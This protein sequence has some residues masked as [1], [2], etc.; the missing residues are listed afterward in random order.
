MPP[1]QV[2]GMNWLSQPA[3]VFP[4]DLESWNAKRIAAAE[5]GEPAPT[6]STSNLNSDLDVILDPHF[7]E[8]LDVDFKGLRT[9]QD[10]SV[11]PEREIS[12]TSTD[13]SAVSH[14]FPTRQRPPNRVEIQAGIRECLRVQARAVQNSKQPFG[15]CLIGADNTTVLLTQGNVDHVNH[16]ECTLAR[17]AAAQFT[18]EYLWTC[19]LYSTWEPCAMCASTIYWANIGRIVYA[20]SNDQLLQLTGEKNPANM[21]M[22]W[23]CREI[24]ADSQKNIEVIGP[25]P[26]IDQVVMLESDVYWSQIRGKMSDNEYDAAKIP[27]PTSTGMGIFDKGAK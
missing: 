1:H 4:R 13:N 21:T 19:T 15:A 10:N 6:S 11:D 8:G 17:S 25:I 24:L 5:K 7:A 9:D 3:A 12:S 23:H 20:A 18:Q 16:A 22:K 2:N 27:W 26:G 14:L